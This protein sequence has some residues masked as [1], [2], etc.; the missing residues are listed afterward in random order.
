MS[1][2]S[3]EMINP[4]QGKAWQQTHFKPVFFFAVMSGANF[5][6]FRGNIIK[7]SR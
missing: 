5:I 6:R 1:S 4:F 2:Y 3:S 7:H